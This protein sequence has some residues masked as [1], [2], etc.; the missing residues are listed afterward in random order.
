[1][2]TQAE[3]AEKF[4]DQT[5]H[6]RGGE[7]LTNA[8]IL[9][10]R[11]DISGIFESLENIE[12]DEM[13]EKASIEAFKDISKFANNE[14]EIEDMKEECSTFV[15][16]ENNKFFKLRK[17]AIPQKHFFSSVRKIDD[18]NYFWVNATKGVFSN[19]DINKYGLEKIGG[20]SQSIKLND[21]E[22]TAYKK[23]FEIRE[24][25]EDVDEALKVI[26]NDLKNDL[27]SDIR[28]QALGSPSDDETI[29]L[30][31]FNKIRTDI[32]PLREEQK[33][34][35]LIHVM[36]IS[37]KTE[38]GSL[39]YIKE[40]ISSMRKHL[41]SDPENV[42]Y[43]RRVNM[44]DGVTISDFEKN[45]EGVIETAES[46]LEEL[47]GNM[48]L[49]TI[50]I[51][52]L[53]THMENY[54]NNASYA[55][56]A[57][58]LS[59]EN[60]KNTAI[61]LAYIDHLRS[62]IQYGG[63]ELPSNSGFSMIHNIN[64]H[65][66][67]NH[68]N[69]SNTSLRTDLFM[70]SPK[71]ST[72]IL[73]VLDYLESDVIDSPSFISFTTVGSG[74]E[75]VSSSVS[76]MKMKDHLDNK[77]S[78]NRFIDSLLDEYSGIYGNQ[79]KSKRLKEFK[80]D[81]TFKVLNSIFAVLG[82]ESVSDEY[83][84]DIIKEKHPD[85]NLDDSALSDGNNNILHHVRSMYSVLQEKGLDSADS[86]KRIAHY[87]QVKS[88][89]RDMVIPEF[90]EANIDDEGPGIEVSK[91]SLNLG[92]V[93][94]S[95]IIAKKAELLSKDLWYARKDSDVSKDHRYK[96]IRHEDLQS[97]YKNH[98]SL[99]MNT[100]K[101]IQSNDRQTIIAELKKTYNPSDTKP[102]V[103]DVYTELDEY[104]VID[105]DWE[106]D[107]LNEFNAVSTA[108][109]SD[110]GTLIGGTGPSGS[111]RSEYIE[112]DSLTDAVGDNI[113]EHIR[114]TIYNYIQKKYSS[115]NNLLIKKIEAEF[116]VTLSSIFNKNL[117]GS[118]VAYPDLDLS[119]LQSD[120]YQRVFEFEKQYSDIIST[121]DLSNLD[122]N[123][124]LIIP[125]NAGINTESPSWFADGTM[126]K[127]F[128]ARIVQPASDIDKRIAT[129]WER[130]EELDDE[131]YEISRADMKRRQIEIDLYDV[132]ERKYGDFKSDIILDKLN[133]YADM[134][135][136]NDLSDME[137]VVRYIAELK[138]RLEF[139]VEK[140]K[141]FIKYS[142]E[143]AVIQEKGEILKAID[144]L[145]SMLQDYYRE[146]FKE[147]SIHYDAD[148]IQNDLD[149]YS[150][151]EKDVL[152]NLISEE[153]I[154]ISAFRKLKKLG[155][156]FGISRDFLSKHRHT[157]RYTISSRS[158]ES[159]S[160]TSKFKGIRRV[161]DN[162]IDSSKL[163]RHPGCSF[164][165]DKP[166]NI[167]SIEEQDKGKAGFGV[168]ANSL[169]TQESHINEEAAQEELERTQVAD[170]LQ[171]FHDR[172]SDE[173][174]FFDD[175]Q[176]IFMSLSNTWK[177][178]DVA[179]I[180]L[181]LRR[182]FPLKLNKIKE[183]HIDEEI[184]NLDVSSLNNLII[185]DAKYTKFE[186]LER[187]VNL[188]KITAKEVE[189][190]P[191]KA[192]IELLELDN[193]NK[194]KLG[195]ITHLSDYFDR[196]AQIN[197][198]GENYDISQLD[199]DDEG[200]LKILSESDIEEK[201]NLDYRMAR[202][203][204][205][206]LL[207]ARFYTTNEVLCDSLSSKYQTQ[208]INTKFGADLKRVFGDPVGTRLNIQE[209]L[210]VEI[211]L[212]LDSIKIS[213]EE[214][215]INNN[216]VKA[217]DLSDC[218]N[219]EKIVYP[220]ITKLPKY[221][222]IKSLENSNL[223]YIEFETD[224]MSDYFV[225]DAEI[226]S[227][228]IDEFVIKDVR[229]EFHIEEEKLIDKRMKDLEDVIGAAEP[230][231]YRK[232][233][234]LMNKIANKYNSSTISS[235]QFKTELGNMFHILSGGRIASV[236]L[237]KLGLVNYNIDI[238]DLYQ[239]RV[240]EVNNDKAHPLD[241]SY[242]ADLNKINVD[243]ISKL[244]ADGKLI[245]LDTKQL[246]IQLTNIGDK[247]LE[248]IFAKDAQFNGNKSVN[249]LHIYENYTTGIYELRLSKTTTWAKKKKRS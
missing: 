102:T 194:L 204:L 26:I 7:F 60:N 97:I 231:F 105:D 234:E 93:D 192:H 61:K 197:I 43:K 223:K 165:N 53:M 73:Q 67:N 116:K 88:L 169:T 198:D 79:V 170:V 133:T 136:N 247:K 51:T 222:N 103:F 137:S 227:K 203:A 20:I 91:L 195:L 27:I 245:S 214:I 54:P 15:D 130:P 128:M 226:N 123:L 240:I 56:R 12:D 68:R 1:M 117:A 131:N 172:F 216:N 19:A 150:T 115:N 16:L 33:K 186:G 29:A 191:Y 176:E 23:E 84:I 119:D 160:S 144:T 190:L 171:I 126:D 94:L 139:G 52:Q 228:P 224:D 241:L 145:S 236:D 235:D 101:K 152:R 217:L 6:L 175:N 74:E 134:L 155:G 40:K 242:I 44:K 41:E 213:L 180:D 206:R 215:N 83:I 233:F 113:G 36:N 5:P 249:K 200:Y 239:L 65:I 58:F 30:D 225:T 14:E 141:D 55:V 38:E 187:C 149:A 31:I 85:L 193:I 9:E 42:S 201:N 109:H 35:V 219:L 59:D 174:S 199:I 220:K 82:N 163:K 28:I 98:L 142:N 167:I 211:D 230:A 47:E 205:F 76:K 146:N 185:I 75:E 108:A 179:N 3:I 237:R 72:K 153:E 13:R 207:P 140:S 18:D 81:D 118:L 244:R 104:D 143:N 25:L 11:G 89:R 50:E 166:L 62:A 34:R 184:D 129:G 156:I 2:L 71:Y 168:I 243:Y 154:A 135:M 212:N 48:P 159:E 63:F 121:L 17:A 221:G 161:A 111:M 57:E 120:I 189:L 138:A 162:D 127:S 86:I 46:L 90:I 22:M 37:T 248:S 45:N 64:K 238:D 69:L 4:Y 151:E 112:L 181:K 10:N 107:I 77:K 95:H 202:V 32:N 218:N 110:P 177:G 182:M 229:G 164:I 209:N 188:R 158:I 49:S 8:E 178:E 70:E 173:V 183:I 125:R 132:L 21:T 232:N 100:I 80:L 24:D 124:R 148:Q 78:Y 99:I 246:P 122:L 196:S 147:D 66:L 39:N 157:S 92:V 208:L 210:G 87:I 106:K 96:G 114:R